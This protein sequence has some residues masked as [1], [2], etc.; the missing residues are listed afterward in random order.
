MFYE[1]IRATG[2]YKCT[3]ELSDIPFFSF[4]FFYFFLISAIVQNYNCPKQTPIS[5][6]HKSALLTHKYHIQQQLASMSR[7][8]FQILRK[9]ASTAIF[10][11]SI[12]VFG[13]RVL[14]SALVHIKC[15][16][17]LQHA[18]LLCLALYPSFS[19]YNRNYPSK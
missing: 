7:D 13:F 12:Q 11:S 9:V 16:A 1:A 6:N 15:V 8:N 5:P 2:R 14:C 17:V 18:I 19:L 4:F 3:R 10:D